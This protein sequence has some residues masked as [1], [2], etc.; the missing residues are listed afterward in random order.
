MANIDYNVKDRLPDETLAHLIQHFS[1]H[2]LRNSD[3]SDPDILGRAYEYLIA[4]F[5]GSAGK[6]GGEFYTPRMVVKL[7]VELLLPHEAM[8][9][10]DPT[11]GS[12]GM[13]IQCVDYIKRNG[14]NPLPGPD[15]VLRR[16]GKKYR[17]VGY[18]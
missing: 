5:A 6:K 4:Q 13:L 2:R 16:P 18:L 10:C 8:R 15:Y 9:V 17:Y 1:V 7:L 11:V 12:G 3:L 14:G